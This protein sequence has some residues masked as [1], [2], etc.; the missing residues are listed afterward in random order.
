MNFQHT[1][2]QHLGVAVQWSAFASDACTLPDEWHAVLHVHPRRDGF[3]PQYRRLLHAERELLALPAFSG[4]T[5]VM[6]RYFLSDSTNQQP[7]VEREDAAALDRIQQPP[8]DGAKIA[9]WLYLQRG[10]TLEPEPGGVAARREH[11]RH[12]WYIGKVSTQGDSGEQTSL[13]L[14]D[15]V[16]TLA[17]Q[18]ATLAGNCLRTWFF[19]RDVDTNYAPLVRARRHFFAACGL[20][21]ATH[22]IAS[23][24]IGG[25][26]SCTAALVQ[27]SA[28]AL[29]GHVP[30]QVWHLHAPEYLNPTHEYGVTFER[31]TAVQYADR[32][33]VIVS[34]T[35]SIDRHGVVVHPGDVELQTRRMW[36]NVEALLH[37]AQMGFGDVA[38]S[39]V[40]LRDAADYPLVAAMFR[41][42]FPDMPVLF[43]H[44]PVCRPAWLIEMEC[45]AIAPIADTRYAP[46]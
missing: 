43:V 34:G 21:P 27:L 6:R 7:L 16:N 44:A 14:A 31:A 28:Y 36:E 25:Q 26:P 10:V 4:A 3:E 1:F 35:A 41:E 11:Y 38:Q 40:Y 39:I 15:Y 18:N 9:A 32:R 5:V 13:L 45:M 8:L 24:G 37:E 12:L 2:F 22:Y 19:V 33:H 17:S 23:T 42:R 46:F 29:M 20:T 30:E